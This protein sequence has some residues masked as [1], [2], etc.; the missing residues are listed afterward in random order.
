M[1]RRGL[2]RTERRLALAVFLPP[3]VCDAL[4][5]QANSQQAATRSAT[6]PDD[7][8]NHDERNAVANAVGDEA[9]RHPPEGRE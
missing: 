7:L 5:E 1:A 9:A 6:R 4:D 3:D 8:Q 2:T